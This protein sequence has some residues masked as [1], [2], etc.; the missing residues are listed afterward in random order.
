[1]VAGQPSGVASTDFLHRLGLLL[2]VWIRGN[3]VL[4]R[5]TLNPGQPASPFAHLAWGLAPLGPCVKYTPVAMMILT[6]GQLHLLI[7]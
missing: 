4:G 3:Q 7:T 5:T 1:V 2:F 6:F